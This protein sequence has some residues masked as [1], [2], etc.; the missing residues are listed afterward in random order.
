M[1]HNYTAEIAN[2]I[3]EAKKA[4]LAELLKIAQRHEVQSDGRRFHDNFYDF[5]KEGVEIL[6]TLFQYMSD[7]DLRLFAGVGM[8]VSQAV[9]DFLEPR[10]ERLSYQ[11]RVNLGE[12][13]DYWRIWEK[14]VT[15]PGL[16]HSEISRIRNNYKC[17]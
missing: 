1:H 8:N 7:A 5:D 13:L 14:M 16:S 3:K 17:S 6:K 12:Y 11:G 9:A 15:V 10:I 2:A 4:L